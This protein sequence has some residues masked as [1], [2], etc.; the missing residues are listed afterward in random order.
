MSLLRRR[1]RFDRAVDVLFAILSI[2]ILSIVAFSAVLVTPLA[3][4]TEVFERSPVA[5]EAVGGTVD[6]ID[7]SFWAQVLSSNITVVDPNGA[8][9][10]TDITRL[11]SDGRIATT[12]FDELTIP[13]RYT[14]T[15]TELSP[16]GDIQSA[17]FFFVFDPESDSRALPLSAATSDGGGPNWVLL[18]AVSGVIL[19]LAGLMWPK[20]SNKT[21]AV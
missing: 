14:V 20:R 9:M 15:H 11:V 7:I 2:V 16:D 21:A 12:S 5:G 8:D 10:E 4:H 1:R 13:G 3:A 6:Q 17:E 18:A 19:I